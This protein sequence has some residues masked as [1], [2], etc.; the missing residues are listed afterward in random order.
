M[1]KHDI[2]SNRSI[3][4]RSMAG[5]SD[6]DDDDE[7]EALGHLAWANTG[8]VVVPRDWLSDRL[9]DAG[10]SW[11]MPAPVW[12]SS[13]YKR[14]MRRLLTNGN[15]E[16]NLNGFEVE[17]KLKD[18]DDNYRNLVA[19]VF[20]SEERIGTPGGEW[21]SIEVGR[22]NYDAEEQTLRYACLLTDDDGNVDEDHV[23]YERWTKLL[24]R[25][26][27]LFQRMQQSHNGQDLR[28]KVLGKLIDD[29][30]SITLRRSGAVYFFPLQWAEE[31]EALSDIWTAMNRYKDDGVPCVIATIPVIDDDRRRDLIEQR[32]EEQLE[33]EVETA[34]EA[35][36]ERLTGDSGETADEIAR[37]ILENL[38]QASNIADDYSDLLEVRLSIKRYIREWLDDLDGESE[39]LV[40]TV[41]DQSTV[42]DHGDTSSGRVV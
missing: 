22:F 8:D 40:E 23:L 2:T 30:T 34:L 37:G 21:R 33:T 35:G 7:A 38:E 17:F 29:T 24:G 41:L 26:Q 3:D 9:D 11:L 10:L 1:S 15:K 6:L 14:A 36:I 13:A 20:Y 25:A 27:G 19:E 16:F 5:V 4:S 39:E 12:T 32:V 42:D 31:I 28:N 18:G